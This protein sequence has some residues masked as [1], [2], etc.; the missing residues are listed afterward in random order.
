MPELP[1]VETIARGLQDVVGQRIVGVE[2]LWDRTVVVV[3]RGDFSARVK[4]QRIDQVGRR[5][6]WLVIR[7]EGGDYLFIHLRMSGRILVDAGDAPVDK[8]ARVLLDLKDERRIRFSDQRKFGRMV[9]TADPDLVIGDLGPEPLS[10]DLTAERLGEM[11]ARRR[12][13]L[14]PLLLN[15]RFLAGLGNIYT[16]EA[17]WLARI[18]P[19]RTADTLSGD[20]VERLHEAVREVLGRAIVSGGTTLRDEQ[21]VGADGE[22]GEFAQQLQAYDRAGDP[23]ARCGTSIVRIVVAQRGTHL[24][25]HCQPEVSGP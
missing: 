13:R 15:Q 7:L 17:L 19:L 10:D 6:K 12:G 3:E 2:V 25:P 1:E 14:K 20:E 5:G 8:H 21:Y 11:L 23:C 18:H 22:A 4:G 24:C 9:L 16:D